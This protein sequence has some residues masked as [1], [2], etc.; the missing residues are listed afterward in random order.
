MVRCWRG[1]PTQTAIWSDRVTI[2]VAEVLDAPIEQVWAFIGDFG[3]LKRWHPAVRSCEVRGSG[4][5]ALRVVELDGWHA[6]E[7]LLEYD[8]ASFTLG[9]EMVD[10]GKQM[11]IGVRGTMR[12]EPVSPARCRILWTS[13]M[14]TDSPQDLEPMLQA[15][16]P[17]RIAHLRAALG[18]TGAG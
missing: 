9:Y 7:R 8:P 1:F 11:L 14:P 10:C 12:L 6:A 13:E 3:G 4:I 17:A 18:L 5:G 15:Y 2:R 16:Y